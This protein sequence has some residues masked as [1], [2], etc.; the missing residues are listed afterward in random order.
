MGP[1]QVG[2]NLNQA[3]AC[4]CTYVHSTSPATPLS[5]GPRLPSDDVPASTWQACAECSTAPRRAQHACLLACQPYRALSSRCKGNHLSALSGRSKGCPRARI[6]AVQA[7]LAWS[8]PGGA[9]G[10]P[11]LTTAITPRGKVRLP[12]STYGFQ[13][14]R[15]P[16]ALLALARYRAHAHNIKQAH[17]LSEFGPAQERR[18]GTTI[19]TTALSILDSSPNLTLHHLTS[20]PVDFAFVVLSCLVLYLA[21]RSLHERGKMRLGS[22][23]MLVLISGQQSRRAATITAQ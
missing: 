19:T 23:R 4:V 9:R 16:L 22:S 18:D 7:Q 6:Q 8:P 2:H 3:H 1:V 12:A 21:S 17:F 14:L 11:A 15:H 20:W 10:A 5:C 13:I